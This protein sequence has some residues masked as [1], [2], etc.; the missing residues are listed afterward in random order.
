MTDLRTRIAAVLMV[1]PDRMDGKCCRPDVDE[2]H[3]TQE[4]WA[5]HVADAII[6]ELQL[7]KRLDANRAIPQ[8]HYVTPWQKA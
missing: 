3:T 2:W 5:E 7:T 8:F 6:S 4:E 1:H